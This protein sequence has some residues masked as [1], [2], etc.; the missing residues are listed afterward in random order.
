MASFTIAFAP[1]TGRVFAATAAKS[2]G[3]SGEEKGLLDF[4]LG[5]LAKEESMLEVDPVLKKVEE[6]GGSG[7]TGGRKNSVAV[8]PKKNGGGFGSIFAKK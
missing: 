3:G 4:I 1:M 6:K 5:G 8:P 7:T 2:A